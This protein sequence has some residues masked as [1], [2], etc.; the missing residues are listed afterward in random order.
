MRFG[1]GVQPT[2]GQHQRRAKVLPNDY[3]GLTPPEARSLSLKG[4]EAL[5]IMESE[6]ENDLLSRACD[7]L[8]EQNSLLQ[9]EIELLR[10]QL[11]RHPSGE[12]Q[13]REARRQ[14]EELVE[15]CR[16]H[17]PFPSMTRLEASML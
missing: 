10:A 8:L 17:T 15:T 5:R 2:P 9:Q 3:S 11:R 13:I 16:G 1:H 7:E 12:L 4:E 6:R 14:M